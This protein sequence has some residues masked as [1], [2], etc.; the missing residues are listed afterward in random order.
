[1]DIAI[2]MQGSAAARRSKI[3]GISLV[4]VV[5]ISFAVYRFVAV[6]ANAAPPGVDAGNWLAFGRELLGE[7]VKA[8]DSAYPPI[9]PVLVGI[10]SKLVGPWMAAKFIGV[11]ASVSAAIP[12]YLIAASSVGEGLAVVATIAFVGAGYRSEV[13]AFGGYPQ[14]LAEAFLLLTMWAFI[15]SVVRNNARLIILAALFG[16]LVIGTHHLT[17]IYLVISI[18]I[19]GVALLLQ[20]VQVRHVMKE[21]LFLTVLTILF[22]SPYYC[23]Y[24]SMLAQLS[25]SPFNAQGW[26]LWTAGE[27]FSYIFRNSVGVWYALMGIS[28]LVVLL[29]IPKEGASLRIVATTLLAGSILLF[30]CFGEVRFLQFLFAGITLGV[31]LFLAWARGLLPEMPLYRRHVPLVCFSVA[32]A[33]TVWGGILFTRQA[34]PWYQV[35][36]APRLEALEWLRKATPRNSLIASTPTEN[37]W[38]IGWWIEGFSG[39]RTIIGSDARWMNFHQERVHALLVDSIVSSLMSGDDAWAYTVMARNRISYLFIDRA[40]W[41]NPLV[42]LAFFDCVF[43]NNAVVI[44]KTKP[45][46]S[47][48]PGRSR[49]SVIPMPTWCVLPRSALLSG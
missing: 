10:T 16:S 12:L 41:K 19:A 21:I 2:G 29:P 45:R 6:S 32:T 33:A 14:L 13:F 8:A 42:S 11:F 18:V 39:R 31:S 5:L 9:L 25:S 23:I 34:L 7:D 22:A 43:E 28:A 47:G 3:F 38:A 1:M 40:V 46:E 30:V 4:F 15:E 35:I 20:G 17:S 49:P 24:H 36:D 44:L 37:G 48:I 26:S 27:T